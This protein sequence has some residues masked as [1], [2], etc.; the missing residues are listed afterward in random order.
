MFSCRVGVIVGLQSV[1]INV[2]CITL[3][4]TT[5]SSTSR[6]QRTRKPIYDGTH[7]HETGHESTRQYGTRKYGTNNVDS[8]VNMNQS[9][10]HI[11]PRISRCCS[12]RRPSETY[13]SYFR[14]AR[15]HRD[16]ARQQ[17]LQEHYSA[18]QA[19]L[20]SPH[21]DGDDD[22]EDLAEMVRHVEESIY[23]D[24]TPG[25]YFAY[26]YPVQRAHRLGI[27]YINHDVPLGSLTDDE[28]NQSLQ[29]A[30]TMKPEDREWREEMRTSTKHGSSDSSISPAAVKSGNKRRDS[31]E[32]GPDPQLQ[33]K[34]TRAS[35]RAET[36]RVAAISSDVKRKRGQDDDSTPVTRD[37][38]GAKKRST[39][40]RPLPAVAKPGSKRTKETDAQYFQKEKGPG[41]KRRR[42]GGITQPMRLQTSALVGPSRAS[43]RQRDSSAAEEKCPRPIQTIRITRAQRR[44]SSGKYAQLFQLGQRGELDVQETSS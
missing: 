9:S 16:V 3:N 24:S 37:Q 30:A 7:L 13:R 40:T 36:L 2:T 17:F 34:R 31:P 15:I 5:R 26:E 19:R 1:Q 11:A 8:V 39:D 14:R 25:E 43:E 6:S 4:L 27:P 12:P 41:D 35:T 38:A 22:D 42:T 44:L 28:G 18:R 32:E 20:L 29:D 23:W 10:Q 21:S 33:S